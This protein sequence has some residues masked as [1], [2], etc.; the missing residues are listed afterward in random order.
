MLFVAQNFFS[1]TV[2]YNHCV[3]LMHHIQTNSNTN[4]CDCVFRETLD[5]KGP[6]VKTVPLAFEASLER[7]VYL[8]LR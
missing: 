1:C 6:L 7:E 3:A 2:I 4:I 5:H 8:V